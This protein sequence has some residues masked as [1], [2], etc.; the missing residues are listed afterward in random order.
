MQDRDVPASQ[1]TAEAERQQRRGMSN[2]QMAA[3]MVARGINVK[4]L[5]SI[6]NEPTTSRC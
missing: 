2:N 1:D 5:R 3:A 4:W 6:E